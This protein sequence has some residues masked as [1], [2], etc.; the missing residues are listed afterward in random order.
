MTPS[1]FVLKSYPRASKGELSAA[2]VIRKK[3]EQ[4]GQA[5]PSLEP[6]ISGVQKKAGADVADDSDT[7]AT[8]TPHTPSN[9][10][11]HRRRK[12]RGSKKRPASKKRR[13]RRKCPKKDKKQRRRKH[14]KCSRSRKSRR[15]GKKKRK[16]KQKKQKNGKRGNKKRR[17]VT[18]GDN[19]ESFATTEKPEVVNNQKVVKPEEASHPRSFRHSNL[20]FLFNKASSL[21]RQVTGGNNSESFATT[22]KPEVV[23]NQKVVK[24]EEASHPRSF[25]HSNAHVV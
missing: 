11:R 1:G 14:R 13:R 20:K 16:N 22:E 3:R 6:V 7:S 10:Q 24:P 25:R 8:V 23:N 5:A 15:N 21:R 2:P 4:T 17:Q 9:S 12:N 19:S 18:G